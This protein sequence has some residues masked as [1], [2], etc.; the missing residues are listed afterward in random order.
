[1]TLRRVLLRVMLWCLG[2]AAGFGVLSVL[3]SWNETAW[4]IIGTMATSAVAAGLLMAA[5]LLSERKKSG[6]A[7][8]LG[9]CIVLIEWLLAVVLIWDLPQIFSTTPWRLEERLGLTMILGLA[10][11]WAMAGLLATGYPL[12]R[13]AGRFTTII[14]AICAVIWFV[15]IWEWTIGRDDHLF[16]TGVAVSVFG[17]LATFILL[18][19]S[20]RRT[21][22]WA[23][24]LASMVGLILALG[25]IWLQL[26]GGA[27]G[28]EAIVS[29][30][31][32]AAYWSAI[33]L[34][35]V[36]RPAQWLKTTVLVLA[37]ITTLAMDVTIF[38]DYQKIDLD[39]VR[40]L[41]AAAVILTGCG[42]L[43]LLVLM[44]LARKEIPSGEMPEIQTITLICPVCSK[45]VTGHPGACACAHCGLGFRIEIKEPRCTACNYL[46]LMLHS[47]RCP[48]CGAPVP[49]TVGG[50]PPCASG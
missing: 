31:L 33:R 30:S 4:R 10:S 41:A 36:G 1:M 8:L 28:F 3:L 35:K 42:T 2:L 13:I 6:P 19:F 50:T 34:V 29:V 40:R 43:A 32:L 44:R 46:L 24:L 27:G 12:T 15:A 16:A 21:W 11:L 47:D 20:L 5:S 17:G 23:G 48:E 14:A 49:A 45:R 9:M 18:D 39:M 25:S 22:V 38:A 26:K 7:G 37:C